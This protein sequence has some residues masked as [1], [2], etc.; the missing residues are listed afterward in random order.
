MKDFAIFGPVSVLDPRLPLRAAVTLTF[1]IVVRAR[2][3]AWLLISRVRKAGLLW[4]AAALIAATCPSLTARNALVLIKQ[5]TIG[6]D[7]FRSALEEP[8]K[9][10]QVS[11]ERRP[12]ARVILSQHVTHQRREHGG[13]QLKLSELARRGQRLGCVGQIFAGGAQRQDI[14][15][16]LDMV[17]ERFHWRRIR[18]Q[19]NIVLEPAEADLVRVLLARVQTEPSNG[20]RLKRGQ[21]VTMGRAGDALTIEVNVVSAVTLLRHNLPKRRLE[22]AASDCSKASNTL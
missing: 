16:L 11:R 13:A 6:L 20:H 12:V 4:D 14:I 22:S 7:L 18:I 9:A 19:K 8:G 1:L 2:D 3:L 17:N 21:D 5:I 15:N 10:S